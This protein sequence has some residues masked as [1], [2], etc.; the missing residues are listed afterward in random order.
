MLLQLIPSSESEN[1]FFISTRPN[2]IPRLAYPLD[3]S[4]LF[5][6]FSPAILAVSHEMPID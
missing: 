5:L 4:L 6:M 3:F 2:L 1:S